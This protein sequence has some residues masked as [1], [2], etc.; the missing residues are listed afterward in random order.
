M[1]AFLVGKT[2][3]NSLLK[4]FRI[5]AWNCGLKF[6]ENLKEECTLK[7]KYLKAKLLFYL[8]LYFML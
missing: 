3:A 2:I 7:E 1:T 4:V 8:F 5:D 6:S